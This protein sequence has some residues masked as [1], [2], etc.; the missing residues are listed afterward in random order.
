MARRAWRSKRETPRAGGQRNHTLRS[1]AL[2]AAAVA[3]AAWGGIT[4]QH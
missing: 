3:P 4:L 2:L 1:S